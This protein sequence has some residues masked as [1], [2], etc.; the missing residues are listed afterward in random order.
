MKRKLYQSLAHWKQKKN[1]NPLILN[2][3]RQVGKTY[4]LQK[5]GE[6]HFP[7]Y[8]Y[9]NFEKNTA[10]DK[11]F[12]PDLDPH[13]IINEI[14]LFLRTTINIHKDLLI[15]DEIISSPL[16]LTSLKNFC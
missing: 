16:S 4:L 10:L 12:E 14:Q 5:F 1:R 6:E 2:G 11:I 9:L 15:F 8:H 7:Q 3:V 13:R